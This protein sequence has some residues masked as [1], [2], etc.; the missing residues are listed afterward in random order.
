[1][2]RGEQQKKEKRDWC[3]AKNRPS[4]GELGPQTTRKTEDRCGR[5]GTNSAGRTRREEKMGQFSPQTP[6]RHSRKQRCG[7]RKKRAEGVKRKAPGSGRGKPARE[8]DGTKGTNKE[9][10]R[11]KSK[12]QNQ[13]GKGKISKNL[14]M[15]SKHRK[16]LV[17]GKNICKIA[18]RAKS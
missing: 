6:R 12:D 14:D 8:L 17:G 18:M 10:G 2:G 1:L 15:G 13:E 7:S 4:F 11:K 9:K 16:I 5:I 3:A